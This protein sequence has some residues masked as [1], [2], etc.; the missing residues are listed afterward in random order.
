MTKPTEYARD[1]PPT[2]GDAVQAFFEDFDFGDDGK[3]TRLS[4]RSGART[5]L[6]F[7]DE[8]PTL[9]RSSPVQQLSSS[10]R[11]DF[12]AWMQTTTHHGP[13]RESDE[14]DQKPGTG[15]SPSSRRLYLQALNR[16]LRFWWYR[17]WL[18]FSPEE[19]QRARQALQIQTSK[20]DRQRVQTR[21]DQVPTDFGD[22]MLAAAKDLPLPSPEELPDP[23]E[24]RKLRLETLRTRALVLVLR[25]TALRAGDVS[26]LK[27]TDVLLAKQSA[28]HL[29]LDMAKTG[30]TAHIVLGDA[31]LDAIDLYLKERNDASPW[32]FIQ[33]GRTG[34]P[35]Q[36]KALSSEA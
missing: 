9:R 27:R 18:T 26:T 24:R 34:A 33:H 25:A 23:G 5:F 22:R 35:P 4:Y 3:R 6:R 32:V 1:H 2:I 16:L 14:V 12:N 19:E 13:G 7:I 29:R 11:A 17:E 28:G 30:L 21:S 10:V 8:H 36:G 15:Y 31:V 20:E